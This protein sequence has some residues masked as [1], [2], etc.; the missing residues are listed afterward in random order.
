MI[1]KQ[2]LF[3]IARAAGLG[4]TAV[5]LVATSAAVPCQ[6]PQAGRV[7]AFTVQSNC[8]PSGQ[9]VVDEDPNGDLTITGTAQTGLPPDIDGTLCLAA[10][11]GL[12]ARGWEFYAATPNDEHL[13]RDW[14]ECVVELRDDAGVLPFHCD[15]LDAGSYCSGT[16]SP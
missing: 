4:A 12:A 6:V 13:D 2:R 10:D 3:S 11:A 15:Y 16:L 9:I 8:G 5:F 14:R 7:E 1:P